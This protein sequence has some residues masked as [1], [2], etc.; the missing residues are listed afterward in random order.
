MSRLDKQ[1]LFKS[2]RDNIRVFFHQQKWKETMIFLFFVL[3]SLGLWYLQSLQQDYE[4]EIEIPIKYKNIPA[5]MVLTENN[6]EIVVAKVRDK[7]TVLLNYSW[8]RTFAPIEVNMKDAQPGEN[9]STTIPRRTIESSISKQLIA[10]TSLLSFE[11]QTIQ[12]EY[13]EL[14]SKEIPVR[15]DIAL[16][17]KPGFQLADSMKIIPN[18]VVVFASNTILDSLVVLKTVRR[19]I[20]D[21]DKTKEITVQLQPIEGTRME[22]SEVKVIIPIEEFTEKRFLL[23][24]ICTDIPDNYVLRTFPASI[25]VTCN[26]PMSRFKD[27]TEDNFDIQLPFREFEENQSAGELLLRLT[28]KP[29]WVSDPILNPNMVEFIIEQQNND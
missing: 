9:K 22:P 25:E 11:P 12:V 8:L 15:L 24:V 17:M 21:A 27:L 5:N 19:E 10:S 14:K 2:T 3:L 4:I 23:P 6:P 7:G 26:I 13:S 28:R 29:D 18:K 20:K 16:T 1:H